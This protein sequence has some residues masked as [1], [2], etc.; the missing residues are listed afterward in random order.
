MQKVPAQKK[1]KT[2]KFENRRSHNFSVLRTSYQN[3]LKV[4][5]GFPR[6]KTL[7]D[8]KIFDFTRL[9]CPPC[10]L[11]RSD[12]RVVQGAAPH[13]EYRGFESFS[14]FSPRGTFFFPF[15]IILQIC[16]G[17]V[18]HDLNQNGIFLNKIFLKKSS[19]PIFDTPGDPFEDA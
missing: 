12:G 11:H 3:R 8:H 13:P 19:G 16:H 5:I 10:H 17:Y 18:R 6:Q 2:Q 9:G 14:L 1:R 4:K 7:I 15:C